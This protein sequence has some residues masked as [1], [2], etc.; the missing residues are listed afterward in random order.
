MGAESQIAFPVQIQE[1]FESRWRHA[2]QPEILKGS[3]QFFVTGGATPQCAIK[4]NIAPIS[5]SKT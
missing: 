5:T 2:S 1:T 4:R 3:R